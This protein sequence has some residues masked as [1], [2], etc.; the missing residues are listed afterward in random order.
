[1]FPTAPATLPTPSNFIPLQRV[2]TRHVENRPDWRN[3]GPPAIM[4]CNMVSSILSTLYEPPSLRQTTVHSWFAGMA[5]AC[6]NEWQLLVGGTCCRMTEVEFYYH[7]PTH[8]DWFTHRDPLQTSCGRWYFH[9]SGSGFRGGSFKGL[10]LTFGDSETHGGMLI[11]GLELADGSLISG[12]CLCVNHLMHQ[13][14]FTSVAE[15]HAATAG[16]H[17]AQNNGLL[18]I[19]QSETAF[20]RPIFNTARVGLS[21]NRATDAQSPL[22]PFV[23]RRY[24]FLT[25]PDASGKGRPQLILA[26]H[27]DGHSVRAIR[28]TVRSPTR[29]IEGYIRDFETGKSLPSL[30]P[31][32]Q[33]NLNTGDLC[34]LYGH[35]HEHQRCRA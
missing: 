8:P 26:L 17:A 29:T 7:G 14:G 5:A 22:I 1:M 6:L 23:M 35:W 19:G 15:L 25:R 13:L 10:D 31:F 24:R 33:T 2:V 9:R 16:S 12:P 3:H 18:A 30:D 20:E 11:R 4:E 27:I 34:R 32:L 21:L 28:K